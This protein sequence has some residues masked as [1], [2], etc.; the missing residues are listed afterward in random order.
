VTR[1]A[2]HVTRASFENEARRGESM[3]AMMGTMMSALLRDAD[4]TDRG[5]KEDAGA[6]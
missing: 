3:M 6:G 5:A 4:E 2:M 1:D